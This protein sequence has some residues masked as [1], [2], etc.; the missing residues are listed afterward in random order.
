MCPGGRHTTWDW[1]IE[2]RQLDLRARC[3]VSFRQSLSL[4]AFS[5]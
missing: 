1:R 3:H 5:L 2:T 4:G